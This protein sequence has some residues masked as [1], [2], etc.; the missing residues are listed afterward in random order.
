MISFIVHWLLVITLEVL[1]SSAYNFAQT[2][3]FSPATNFAVGTNPSSVAIGDINGDGQPDLAVANEN[4]HN[5]S[6]LIG[7][8]NGTFGAATNFAA[9]WNPYSVAIGDF[10]GDSKLDLAVT[11]FG[12][13]SVAVLLGQ[14][15]GTFG[16]ATNFPAGA[17][18]Y[19]VAIGDFNGDSKSDLAVANFGSHNVSVLLGQGNGTF[20]TATSFAVGTGPRSVAIGDFNGDSKSDL[21]VANEN[22][23][24]VS[25]LLGQG[26]GTFGAATNFAAGA[27]PWSVAIGD[28]NGDSKSDL[29]VA[30][31]HV[32]SGNN[33]SILLGVGDGTFGA[34]TNFAAGATPVSVAIGGFNC[35]GKS[36]LAVANASSNNVSVLLG[37]GNGTLGTAT[38]FA[39]GTRPHSIAI[40][41][42]NSDSKPD[43]AVANRNSNNVSVLLNTTPCDGSLS[44]FKFN[45]VNSNCV[46]DPLEQGLPGWTINLSG[47]VTLS[48][49]TNN[50]GQYSFTSLPAGT[51]TVSEVLQTG[52]TQ[53][54]PVSPGT[55]IRTISPGLNINNLNFG[56]RRD[57]VTVGSLSGFKF[58]DINGNCIK[59]PLEQVLPGWTINLSGPVNLSTTTNSLGQYS[60][61]SLPAGTYTVSEVLQTGWTQTCPV[62]PGTYTVNL[63]AG[64]QVTGIIF[65]NRDTCPGNIIQN[66]SFIN[67]AV[68][69]AMPSPG[70][71]SNW[72]RAYVSPDVAVP[73]GCGDLAFVGMWGNQAVGEAIQ[74]TLATPLVLGVTYAIEFCARWSPHPGRPYPVQFAFR[75]SNV[76][77]TSP[78]DP[79]GVL[80]GVSQAITQ[81]DWVTMTL[82]NWLATGAFSILTI[83]ATNQ[84]SFDHGDS[85][86][87]GHIDRICIRRTPT[88][89]SLC[90]FKFNDI[91]GNCIKDPLEQ[92]L[93]GWTINLSGP[94]NLST[95]TN[96]L[97][98]YC[99][100]SLPAGTYT[101]SEVLQTGWTQTCPVSPGTY[102]RTISPGLN[103]NNLNFGNRQD[104]D[105]PC[106]PT[107]TYAGKT[108]N[109]I[110]IGTQ[111]WLKENLDIG[112]RIN[113]NLGQTNNGT[114]EKYCYNDDPNNCT[115]YGGL[116]QW[117]EAVQYKNGA[118]N[119]ASPN[120]AFTG[121][122]QGI[123]PTGWHIPSFTE[124]ASIAA[125]GNGL[126]EIGEGTGDG[127]GT[128]TSGF[129]ALLA[130]YRYFD[131]SF[132]YLHSIIY[133]WSPTEASDGTAAQG[134]YLNDIWA[135]FSPFTNLKGLG[136][137]V[138]CL[139]DECCEPNWSALGTGM[140]FYVAALA[141]IGS[142]LYAG[143]RFTTAGGVSANYIAK[144]NGSSWSPL[145]SGMNGAVIA[146]AVI[147][148]DLYAGGEFT[149]AGG[150]NAN[151]I[152]K[153][154]GSSWSALGSGMDATVNALTVHGTDLYAGGNFGTAGGA[155]AN[156]IAQ[157]N[158]SSWSTLG[159]GMNGG[160]AALVVLGTDLYAG[161]AFSTAGGVSASRIAKWNGS[162]WSA[163]GSGMDGSVLA[164]AVIGTDLYAGGGFTTAGGVSANYVAKWDGSSWFALSS[165]M[166]AQI[167]GYA[168]LEG[169]A[170]IGTDLYAGGLFIT[171]GGVSAN[172]IA[173]WNG[174]SWSALGSGT[175]TVT[176]ALAAIGTDL[177]AGGAFTTAG[178]VSANYVAKWGC[179]PIPVSVDEDRSG[180]ALPQLFRLEQSYPNPFNPTTTISYQIPVAEHVSLKVYDML[181]REVSTLVNENKLPG[182]YKVKFDASK[183]SSGIYFYQ[184]KA[185]E[186]TQTKKLVFLK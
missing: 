58:N 121:N 147:G 164:L 95:T 175:N 92:G 68:P 13:N 49:T 40:G 63:S 107:V 37:Q 106:E 48:T 30:N 155:S 148:A 124:L 116:Y 111:C 51:Y 43:I 17:G 115:T 74:Q 125:S 179:I 64:Q 185:G 128:N 181:G 50:L 131:G 39:A 72:T 94:V 102:I 180:N 70:Q 186:F 73:G 96:N 117:A 42:F 65:G 141:V 7:Q 3:S 9:A 99:F 139:K 21:A 75:A 81:Q 130:G 151:Y 145:G 165:G 157:W 183:L 134:M 133:F 56:N 25:V 60:F 126:K 26:N 23:H 150:V 119:T 178:G 89:G 110:L 2:V 168:Q 27:G 162:S 113:G 82:P 57:T 55:Y 149:T 153:W 59:D 85:T 22:S 90:G 160:V 52:W 80:I 166:G 34:A 132:R 163:L 114:I 41:D 86:S 31:S 5:V 93:P 29:A 54:C 44:G 98:Q 62:S 32:V 61:T 158:G 122:V 19:S 67:G 71:T 137:S 83:S 140:N 12:Y 84:S 127:A 184:L 10:N 28:F 146:L 100:T 78:Q 1:F 20:G 135:N 136:F 38:N 154:N 8:G 91:N 173:K 120:P 46:K 161:G 182:K 53:T 103:I 171:A 129:S 170:V 159:S 144:W 109:T 152:A 18:P 167:G 4:S 123:C 45:D 6:V 77:L 14:E 69:G 87:Y 142:D 104:S 24:N 108:Y 33:V 112:I 118:T 88:G 16:A 176:R 15:N 143:G 105:C 138:R 11:N 79:N 66:W 156:A 47:P 101:V 177:Y 76:P 97:G 35:D 172:N 174:S 169:L 36:D